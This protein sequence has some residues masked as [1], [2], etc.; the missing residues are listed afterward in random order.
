MHLRPVE[1]HGRDAAAAFYGD[2][3]TLIVDRGGWKIYDRKDSLI[4]DASEIRR[5]HVA[6]FLQSVRDR[7]FPSATIDIGAR[8]MTLC[9]LGNIAYRLGRELRFNPQS[10][11]FIDDASANEFLATSTR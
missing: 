5:A 7:T 4:A 6:D 8:S 10:L 3:G 1:R 2:E 11:Q 9:H